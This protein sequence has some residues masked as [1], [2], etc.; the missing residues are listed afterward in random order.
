MQG[1]RSDTSGVP[2]L[3][4]IGD[5]DMVSYEGLRADVKSVLGPLRLDCSEVGFMDSA[6]LRLLMERLKVG[7]VTVVA[8]TEQMMRVFAL[9]G[10]AGWAGVT[11]ETRP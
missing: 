6:G 5:I 9:S 4:L 3:R 8:P 2:T 11:I 1:P 10:V 7:P